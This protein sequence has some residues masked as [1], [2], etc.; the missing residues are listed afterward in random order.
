MFR[1][2]PG[3][4]LFLA[5]VLVL[6][7]ELACIRWFPAHVVFLSFFTN[8]V[9][10]ASFMGMSVGCL[11]ARR[12]FHHISWT[13]AILLLAI[14]CGL[15]V[16]GF[17]G[18]LSQM[19]DVGNQE[20]PDVV[21]FGAETG[22]S[23][24]L[25]FQV[26]V[27]LMAGVF[28]LLVGAVLVG[29][30][31]ELGRAFNR[32][33]DRT[34]SYTC[35]LL[36]SLVGIAGFALCSQL[37]L[38]P[39]VW[40][41]VA[42]LLMGY[43]ILRPQPDG[44]EPIRR[45]VP[46]TGL[47]MA[48]LVTIPT[49]FSGTG[50][51]L[52]REVRWSPYYRIDYFHNTRVIVTNQTGHQRIIGRDTPTQAPYDLPYL[53]QRELK[54][55]ENQRVLVIGAGSGNDL[56][57]ALYWCGPD[58]KIDAVEI[59]P[60]IQQYGAKYNPDQPYADPRVTVHLNDGRNFLRK[61]ESGTYDLVI[62]ALVDSLVLHSGYSNIRLESFL[63]SADCFADVRRVLKPDGLVAV[64]N[65]FRQGWIMARLREVLR[66]KFEYD[67]VVLIDPPYRNGPIV[68]ID[69]FF[70]NGG[71][72]VF[73]AGTKEA[74]EPLREKFRRSSF[75]VPGRTGMSKELPGHFS[76][77]KPTLKYTDNKLMQDV[78]DTGDRSD[79]VALNETQIQESN[80]DLK[81]ADDDWPFLYVRR[82]GIPGLTWRG[83]GLTLLLS[84]VL[85]LMFGGFARSPLPSGRGV[86]GKGSSPDTQSLS[87]WGEGGLYARAFLLGAGFML[88]ET[89]AVVQMALLFGSTWIVNTFV[90]AAILLMAVIGNLY[91]GAVKPKRLE[92]Y[93]LGLFAAI[94]VGLAVPLDVFLGMSPV[95]QVVASCTLVFA[96]ILFAG[97]IFPTT[98]ARTARPDWFFAANVAGALI[99]G[100][101]ENASMLLGFRYLL[102]VASGFYALSAVFGGKKAS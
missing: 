98:F 66:D 14:A 45:L 56:V 13:P 79:W 76:D 19:T 52:G 9:L 40:F 23:G 20:K 73:F 44:G 29:P 77:Q 43:F 72:A 1:S 92:P 62:F 32:M 90:F 7:L 95:V 42:A 18:H 75:W 47:I 65:F 54:R 69:T 82:P 31:Q 34:R 3:W 35:N 21:F 48:V 58:T 89:K 46:L 71:N 80:G 39:T 10:L 27:E 91:A 94:G 102:L 11:L 41:A 60:V 93:Y 22:V 37:Q 55:P 68:P 15:V 63:F 12:Q 30:G 36:G 78:P 87:I 2:R 25:E 61:A 51:T 67:P 49:S 53:F 26:P 84:G 85:W 81:T 70:K 24:N 33:T 86:G 4:D 50:F 101:A 97:V 100:L 17:A 99:G 5:S 16:E 83:I 57:R 38:P 28:F 64:Y 96:P 88:I 6:F 59:D 8:T 74:V